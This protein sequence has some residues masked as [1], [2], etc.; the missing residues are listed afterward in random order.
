[1]FSKR[2]GIASYTA[3]LFAVAVI[4]LSLLAADLHPVQTRAQ[5]APF[6][7]NSTVATI[8]NLNLRDQPDMAGSTVATMPVNTRALVVGG[9]FNDYWYWLDYDGTL[10]YALSR[11]L[12]PVDDKYTP[13]PLTPA[14]P[15]TSGT[16]PAVPIATSVVPQSTSIATI[17]AIPTVPSA[18]FPQQ[19]SVVPQQTVSAQ[20]SP[21]SIITTPQT[22][23]DYTGLWLG[24]MAQGG[25][26]RSGPGQDK[27]VVKSWWA[28]RRVLL[29]Q[30]SQDSIGATWYRV[31]EPPEAP[32][33]VHSS[34]IRKVALVKF[35]IARYPGR[36][37][38]VNLSQQ[39][40]TAYQNGMPVMVT[41]ASTGK[42]KHETTIGSWKIYWR[43]PKQTMEGG[44]LA[45]GDYY[46][47]KDVPYPQYFQISGEALHG[48]FWH[49]NFGRPMSHGCVNLS[50]PIA[51][52]FYG[53]ANIGTVVYVHN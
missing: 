31:S 51:G 52:W 37:V 42:A 3:K 25:K 2:H 50:T 23:G 53:W 41:L 24:E 33:W 12:V 14:P 21:T 30:S 38:N 27:S 32:M 7:L 18:P 45:S 28:G 46:K 17:P 40:V 9:P 16:P 22:P 5:S 20:A 48:T 19:T 39:I 49:D 26:V 47:L 15:D 35:E 11:Y 36:W 4:A 29:Y 6:P 10:G 34:L 43:L 13:V 1:M 8:T 44:N